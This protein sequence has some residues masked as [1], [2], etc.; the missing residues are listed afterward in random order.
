M[1]QRTN[2]I[3]LG[4][5]IVGTSV[6]IHLVK[7][8]LSVVLLDRGGA[9]DG[10]SYGNT[11]IIEGNSIFPHRWRIIISRFCRMS[12]R[13][14]RLFEPRRSLPGWSKPRKSSGR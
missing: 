1:A 7:R 13:G 6:A 12:R 5:G 8:G 4:A 10:T 2:V 11:G 3:V 14:W 9:G